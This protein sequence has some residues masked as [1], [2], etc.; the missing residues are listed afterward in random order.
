[1]KLRI[2]DSFVSSVLGL[3]LAATAS[4]ADPFIGTWKMDPARSDVTT[5]KSETY[6]VAPEGLDS[7]RLTRDYV[8]T[9]GAS[10]HNTGTCKFDGKAYPVTGHSL[11]GATRA[12]KRID[13]RTWV[14]TLKSEGKLVHESKDV[15]SEDGNTLT[16]TGT[17]S[18]AFSANQQ[19][20]AFTMVYA[21]Q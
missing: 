9:N 17:I 11:P 7:I 15:V 2:R 20:H 13:A 4:A 16:M 14:V 21:R 5:P 18:N 8:G 12:V 3:L 1:M 10:H 19:T 6:V